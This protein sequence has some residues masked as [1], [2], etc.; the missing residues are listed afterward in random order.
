MGGGS[1]RLLRRTRAIQW[2]QTEEMNMNFDLEIVEIEN[3]DLFEI[4]IEGG[5]CD[6]EGDCTSGTKSK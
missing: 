1:I 4:I 6:A 2:I 3:Y 5:G